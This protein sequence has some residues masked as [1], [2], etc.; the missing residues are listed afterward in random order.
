MQ[1]YILNF[2]KRKHEEIAEE[3]FFQNTIKFIPI[4]ERQVKWY[5]E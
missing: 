5:S 2:F 4:Q 1:C 3:L